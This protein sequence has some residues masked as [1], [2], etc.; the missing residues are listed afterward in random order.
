M[1]RYTFRDGR[2]LVRES[3]DNIRYGHEIFGLLMDHVRRRNEIDDDTRVRA[4]Y[5]KLVANYLMFI[6][7]SMCVYNVLVST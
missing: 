4:V 2:M 3:R 7:S 1:R 6:P 5:S